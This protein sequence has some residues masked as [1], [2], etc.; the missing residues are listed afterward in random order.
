MTKKQH[1]H[2]LQLS[3]LPESPVLSKV[4]PVALMVHAQLCFFSSFFLTPPQKIHFSSG[5]YQW[6]SSG[7]YGRFYQSSEGSLPCSTFIMLTS[8][9]SSSFYCFSYHRNTKTSVPLMKAIYCTCWFLP[10][11]FSWKSLTLFCI[12]TEYFP[13]YILIAKFKTAVLFL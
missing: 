6:P 10:D 5:T 2:T 12:P 4:L 3:V 13:M 7:I 8:T 9:F 11:L 1:S